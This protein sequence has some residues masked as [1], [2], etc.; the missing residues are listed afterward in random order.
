MAFL[1][2]LNIYTSCLSLPSVKYGYHI[3]NLQISSWSKPTRFPPCLIF[4]PTCCIMDASLVKKTWTIQE[5]PRFMTQEFKDQNA[6]EAN[7]ELLCRHFLKGK[8]IKVCPMLFFF[9][10]ATLTWTDKCSSFYPCFLHIFFAGRQL[11]AETCA[12]LQRPHQIV[13][14][15]LRPRLL[16]E[17]K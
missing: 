15:V 3:I 11:S 10:Q 6:L 14:Q 4:L 5:R 8:C 16:L 9:V 13:L 7:G 1:L 2:F 12:G 17:R